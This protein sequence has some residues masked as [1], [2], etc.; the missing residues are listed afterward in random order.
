[1]SVQQRTTCSPEEGRGSMPKA[2]TV[3][4]RLLVRKAKSGCS[5]AFEEL[6]ERHREGIYRRAFRI[7]RNQQDAEDAVQRSFQHAFMKVR[8]F[9]GD[10]TFSTWLTRIAIN[11]ALMLLRQR[12][13]NTVSL[14]GGRDEGYEPSSA[15]NV[16][17]IGPTP[18]QALEKK[19]LRDVLMEAISHLRKSLQAVLLRELRGLTTVETAQHLG[20]SVAAVKARAFHARR[21]LRQHLER[22]LQAPHRKGAILRFVVATLA[23]AGCGIPAARSQENPGPAK[24]VHLIGLTGVKDNAKGTLRVENGQVHFIHGKAS[25]DISVA[26]IEDVVTGTDSTKAVGKTIGMVSMAAPYGGG[27]FLSL[28]RKKIDTLTLKYRD[29]TGSL[30]GVIFTMPAGSANGIERELVSQGAHSESSTRPNPPGA[31][32]TDSASKEPRQ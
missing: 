26:C 19:E 13:T 4:E 1:M 8:G 5:S 3:N 14:E 12:R 30:H 15:L 24:A 21:H 9:R 31:Q 10:S 18:E 29:P 20:L 6:Y 16:V 28:F 23:I 17:G 27:R 11:E 22:R 32:G 7:L 25:S 2:R